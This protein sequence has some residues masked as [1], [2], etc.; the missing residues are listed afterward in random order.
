MAD[1]TADMAEAPPKTEEWVEDNPSGDKVDKGAASPE[2]PRDSA[3]LNEASEKPG[4]EDSGKQPTQPGWTA[5][6]A[7]VTAW[8]KTLGPFAK[9]AD[10]FEFT[11]WEALKKFGVEDLKEIDIPPN[12]AVPLSKKISALF[13][14]PPA[15]PRPTASGSKRRAS[16]AD[17][18]SKKQKKDGGCWVRDCAPESLCLCMGKGEGGRYSG[19]LSWHVLLCYVMLLR[20]LL[21]FALR[22]IFP[23]NSWF[24]A[25]SLFVFPLQCRFFVQSNLF[26][27]LWWLGGNKPDC[28]SWWWRWQKILIIPALGGNNK[29]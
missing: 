15:P 26:C 2:Q 3:S 13:A 12:A 27:G 20:C 9:F 8:I 5:P 6:A 16:E 29:S 10:N 14:P 23:H 17:G 25:V 7:S 28:G 11:D 22:H 24:W 4:Q 1:S 19:V 18:P 21:R